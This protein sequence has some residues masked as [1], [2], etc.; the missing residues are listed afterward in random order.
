MQPKHNPKKP[1]QPK[2]SSLKQCLQFVMQYLHNTCHV[3]L[4]THRLGPVAEAECPILKLQ[5]LHFSLNA[6]FQFQEM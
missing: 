3:A 2:F 5:V 6:L 1:E 4:Y